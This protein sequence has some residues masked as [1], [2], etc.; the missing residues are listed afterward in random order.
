MHTHAH[1]HSHVLPMA[2]SAEDS[3]GRTE[4]AEPAR[5]VRAGLRPG[6]SDA[7]SGQGLAVSQLCVLRL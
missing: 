3:P 5:A 6:G 7:V 1:S 4:V 2:S